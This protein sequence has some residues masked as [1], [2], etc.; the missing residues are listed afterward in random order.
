MKKSTFLIASMT[1][2]L[3]VAPSCFAGIITGGGGGAKTKTLRV[4]DATFSELVQSSPSGAGISIGGKTFRP[5][6]IDILNRKINLHNGVDETI[7]LQSD[8]VPYLEKT[9][10]GYVERSVNP[11]Q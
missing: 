5:S 7:I 3:L 9:D 4:S 1:C 8:A 2:C 10:S 6:T 11:A